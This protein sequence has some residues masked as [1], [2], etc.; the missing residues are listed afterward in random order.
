MNFL[1][2]AFHYIY[3]KKIK[4][5]MQI[6]L[7]SIV[8][9]VIV[10]S[11]ILYTSSGKTVHNLEKSISN[12]VTLTPIDLINAID[13]TYIRYNIRSEDME[14]FIHSK[15]VSKYNYYS[16]SFV[17]FSNIKKYIGDENDYKQV[18]EKLKGSESLHDGTLYSLIESSYDVAFT[19]NGY[20]LIEGRPITSKDSHNKVCLISKEL[21]DLNNIKIGS[22]IEVT[23]V[24]RKFK[25]SLTVVG[26]FM[27]PKGNYLTGT[28]SSPSE[29]IFMPIGAM[30]D[31]YKENGFKDSKIYNACV[32]LKN[33]SDI[34]NF[35][36]EVK[37]KMKIR[38]VYTSH[39][40]NNIGQVP[41]EYEGWDIEKLSNYYSEN[42]W[43]DIQIDKEWFD[44][45]AGP[46]KSVNQSS[47]ILLIGVVGGSTI[48]L[49]LIVILSLNGRKREF[50]I[51]LAMGEYK[52][53]LI[54]QVIVEE[55]T[56]I[57]ISSIIGLIIGTTTGSALFVGISNK[58][59]NNQSEIETINNVKLIDNYNNDLINFSDYGWN[60]S[61]IADLLQ[62]RSSHIVLAY[63]IESKINIV[64]VFYYFITTLLLLFI[65]MLMQMV[66]LF[67]LKPID[68]LKGKN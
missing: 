66:V 57:L 58:I 48:I 26:I 28:G 8:F 13:G 49:I 64:A 61:G 33:I 14:S 59:Y 40:K 51:L 50:G 43:Y 15:Y 2:R 36:S 18:M 4:I 27:T 34:E 62:K 54:G 45:V 67:R 35:V 38:N 29:I 10:S 42:H 21:A 52:L 19:V 44:M 7:F 60:H 6:I 68:I 63:N 9:A 31:Y 39:F 20:S 41:K 30:N 3:Y 32:Y 1:K 65:V 5:L 12:S 56:L 17:K 25:Y 23:D 24:F 55:F 37:N 47:T 22:K 11:I 53:K 16:T 46:I